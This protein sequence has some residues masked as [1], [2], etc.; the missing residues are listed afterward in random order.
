MQ[1]IKTEPP[2]GQNLALGAGKPEET[3]KRKPWKKKSPVDVVR[4]QLDKLREEVA[5]DDAAL[6][7]KKSQ[8]KKLEEAFKVVE[9][10]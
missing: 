6:N 1:P 7:K 9:G 5:E 8:L 3:D 4:E 2:K 10:I